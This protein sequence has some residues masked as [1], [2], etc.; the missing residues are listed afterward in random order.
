MSELPPGTVTFLFT[1][2]EQST[3]L[4]RRLGDGYAAVLAT[5]RVILREACAAHDGREIDVQGDSTFVAFA[6]AHD[7][8][9]AAVEGQAALSARDWPDGGA[10]RVRMGLHTAEAAVSDGGYVGLGV[11]RAARICA[12]A[13]G[14]QIVVSAATRSVLVDRGEPGL[15]L[16]DLG[17]RRLKGMGPPERLYQ[18]TADAVHAPAR[19]GRLVSRRAA[20]ALAAVAVLAAAAGIVASVAGRSG[21]A[22]ALETV[23][24]NTVAAIAPQTNL[25]RSPIAVGAAPGR[26]ASGAGA[27]WVAN[28]DDGTVSRIDPTAGTV[29]K[30]IM[31][32]HGPAG[33]AF[34][35]GA[36]WVA[37]GLDGT[38][39]RIDP[40]LGRAVDTITV[41]NGPDDVLF[42]VGSVWVSNADDHTI[43]RIDPSSDRPRAPIDVTASGLAYGA[44]S[45]WASDRF[46][47]R[48]RRI[49]PGTGRVVGEASVGHG[50][51]AVL[52]AAGALWV[53]NALDGTVSR[54]EPQ[55]VAVTAA[56]RT[57]D[58]PTALAARAGSIWA[59]NEFGG[60]VVRLDPASG[61]ITDT[62]SV[63]QRPHGLAVAGGEMWV[64]VRGSGAGHRGGTLTIIGRDI[65]RRSLDPA[66]AYAPDT[67]RLLSLTGAGL[68]AFKHVGGSAGA[69]LV[70]DVARAV[71]APVD[72][73][74]AYTF[75]LRPGIRYSTGQPLQPS[76]FRRGFERA[77]ALGAASP[78]PALFAALRGAAGCRR[79]PGSCDL[80]SAIQSDERA[81]TVTFHLSAP[82]P[83]FLAKL[84]GTWAL[85][86][87][88]GTPPAPAI[89]P[90][91]G[92]YRIAHFRAGK[93][94]LLV[95]NP[96]F[97]SWS[98]AATPDGY[99]DRIR[100]RLDLTPGKAIIAVRRGEADLIGRSWVGDALIPYLPALRTRFAR[101]LHATPDPATVFLTLNTRVRPFDDLRVRRAFNEGINRDTAVRL[102]G[103]TVAARPTCQVLPA[104][105]PGFRPYC[106]YHHDPA[107]ARALIAASHTAGMRVTI[108][109]IPPLA[110]FGRYAVRVLNDLGYHAQLRTSDDAFRHA[111]NSRNHAQVATSV[112]IADYPAPSTFFTTTLTCRSFLPHTNENGNVAQFCD[113]R[114]DARIAAAAALQPTDPRAADAAWARADRAAVDDAPWVPLVNPLEVDFVSSRVGNYQDPG[115]GTGTLLDQLWVR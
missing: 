34:G 41:G 76:D 96:H 36:V 80:S 84:A 109:G 87:P 6:T 44:G 112:W 62:I 24:A 29:R 55:S 32:G 71:P 74:R 72:N 110:A 91:V 48:V 1:D 20:G 22:R 13:H 17:S 51:T 90:G 113:P 16:R 25:V 18:V 98:Q 2:I 61:E 14:G 3:R 64:G 46:A 103:G 12:T 82:D 63:G 65:R 107:D 66:I 39:S 93:D 85:P 28:T 106:P 97:R 99:P 104:N 19:P 21:T 59:A 54:I 68:T 10:V 38:V 9:C 8:L 73:G 79:H 102:A 40:V 83:E 26:L 42:A 15:S 114:V 115:T 33:I 81:G 88:P 70:P 23:P 58:G 11:H 69:Q 67:N 101:Q 100:T 50:P 92:P 108:W 77:F 57:G 43:S 86:A 52:F 30:T 37:N 31:V 60:T 7:A 89:V 94:I 35:A 78:T 75:S 49:D 53:A 4:L 95:R 27:L 45:L 105:F 56:T 111:G 5:H 47:G